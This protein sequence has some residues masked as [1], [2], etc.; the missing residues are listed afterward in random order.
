MRRGGKLAWVHVASTPTLTR[1]A[2]QAKR[3]SEATD[4]MGILPTS[5]GVSVHDGCTT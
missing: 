1:Y 3:G 5:T 2:V 4:A